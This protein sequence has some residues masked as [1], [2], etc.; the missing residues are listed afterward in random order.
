M[1]A[2]EVLVLQVHMRG[3][4]EEVEANVRAFL[5]ILFTRFASLLA[6]SV[7]VPHGLR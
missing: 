6:T 2:E 7:K 5:T 4:L 1:A 3:D